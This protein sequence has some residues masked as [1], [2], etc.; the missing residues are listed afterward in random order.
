MN[1]EKDNQPSKSDNADNS[2]DENDE[3]RDG[4]NHDDGGKLINDLNDSIKNLSTYQDSNAASNNAGTESIDDFDDTI[5]SGQSS[6][7]SSLNEIT[8]PE[9]Q[10]SSNDV[11]MIASDEDPRFDPPS[12][13]SPPSVIMPP[14]NIY[15]DIRTIP[16]HHWQSGRPYDD[17]SI[18]GHQFSYSQAL[19]HQ[20]HGYGIF[21][22]DMTLNP[23][24]ESIQVA[25]AF[26]QQ[27]HPGSPII[28]LSPQIGLGVPYLGVSSLI[29]YIFVYHSFTLN[30]SE[31]IIQ[32]RAFHP[33]APVIR[34]QRSDNEPVFLVVSTSYPI[35]GRSMNLVGSATN[36]PAPIPFRLTNSYS[37]TP[38]RGGNR[39]R[40]RNRR[41][42]ICRDFAAGY[43][44]FGDN[45]WH[46]HDLSRLHN[47]SGSNRASS[48]RR[49]QPKEEKSTP[50]RK[51]G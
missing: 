41:N 24:Q 42:T 39:R 29:Y 4:S 16:Q 2:F 8:T 31:A 20:V 3:S 38:F 47:S 33:G 18:P 34:M 22:F 28:G 49:R 44:R 27:A 6:T 51:N 21:H 7:I 12:N 14:S 13:Y 25:M 43:C 5:L 45:C 19:S 17:Q 48:R 50:R 9:H 15:S 40:G 32:A 37:P 30:P 1:E 35:Y 26:V 11:Q 36:A 46:S 10:E 23:S